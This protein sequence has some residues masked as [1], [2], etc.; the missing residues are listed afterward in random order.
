MLEHFQH[1]RGTGPATSVGGAWRRGAVVFRHRPSQGRVQQRAR[2]PS[3]S[4]G[5]SCKVALDEGGNRL[6]VRRRGF[7]AICREVVPARASTFMS[8]TRAAHQDAGGGCLCAWT[9]VRFAASDYADREHGDRQQCDWR[10]HIGPSVAVRSRSGAPH[11]HAAPYRPAGCRGE[12]MMDV[13]RID[14][15]R[16]PHIPLSRQWETSPCLRLTTKPQQR[17]CSR[18]EAA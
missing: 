2:R 1:H 5:C 9:L 12:R 15:R 3:I 4:G 14:Q 8:S 13:D 10:A 6:P 16:I 17:R 7:V 18:D 11:L